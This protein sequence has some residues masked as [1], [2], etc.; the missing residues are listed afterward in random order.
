[1]D[2]SCQE[3]TVGNVVK[4]TAELWGDSLVT[5]I[6]GVPVLPLLM[7]K[8]PEI[9]FINRGST[10]D[11]LK[12]LYRRLSGD[13]S[14]KCD[15]ALLWIGTNDV[16][17]H[18]GPPLPAAKIIFRQ[19]WTG[20]GEEFRSYYGRCLDLLTRKAESVITIPPVL[21]GER[22][23]SS[24]NRDIDLLAEIIKETGTDFPTVRF[25]DLRQPVYDILARQDSSGY[26]TRHT[27][28][29]IRDAVFF[30]SGAAVDSVSKKRGLILTLDGVHWNTKGAEIVTDFLTEVISGPDI[31]PQGQNR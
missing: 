21:V 4:R 20:S 23:D 12:S 14:G 10:G 3:R 16:L 29:F 5:G 15:I 28:G 2:K 11:T 18:A 27:P 19:L 22:L 24:L 6:P 9:L 13:K 8:N 31:R 7:E 26:I 30:R 1:M 25:A 17:V